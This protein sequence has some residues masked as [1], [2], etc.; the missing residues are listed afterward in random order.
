MP[1]TFLIAD[2]SDGKAM[3]LEILI[4][5]S[6]I[7]TT[8]VRAKTTDD[9]KKIIDTTKISYAFIDYNM[10]SENGPAV[11]AY[12]R[13]GQPTALIAMASSGNSAQY[14]ADAAQA[15]A[16]AYICTSFR[17]EEVTSSVFALLENWE[18]KTRDS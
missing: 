4:K 3:M 17:E 12:L 18:K 11:I 2:D 15:G 10:P 9:A 16:D 7:S 6:N 13:K 14:R 8:I 1:T 5:K